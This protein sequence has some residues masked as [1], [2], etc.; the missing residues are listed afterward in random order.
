MSAPLALVTE[1][2]KI[3]DLDT[4]RESL[5]RFKAEFQPYRPA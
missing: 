4:I 2:K 5:V 1:R 3:G